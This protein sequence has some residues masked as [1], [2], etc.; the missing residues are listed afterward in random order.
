MMGQHY[1][2]LATLM[3]Y[4]SVALAVSLLPLSG[5]TKAVQPTNEGVRIGHD[6]RNNDSTSSAGDNARPATAGLRGVSES[7][8][9]GGSDSPPG[10]S[11]DARGN[12]GDK[13]PSGTA[14]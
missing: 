2:I 4:V 11:G 6:A 1:H 13:Q 14:A 10:G 12:N 7:A 8:S 5:C 3:K 9:T